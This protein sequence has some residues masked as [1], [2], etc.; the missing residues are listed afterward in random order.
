MR[1][2]SALPISDLA[3]ASKV[4]ERFVGL[5][6]FSPVEQM[7]LLEIIAGEKTDERTIARSLDFCK[8]I[9]KTP[10]VIN[11]GYGFYTTRVFSTYL[12]EGAQLV[13]E[14]HAPAAIEWAARTAG[15]VIGPLQV[16]DEVTLTLARKAMGQAEKY[17]SGRARADEGIA[18]IQAMVDTHARHGK[19]A[20]AGFYNYENGKR[21]GFWPGLAE[22]AKGTVEASDVREVGERLLLIQA[23]EAVR[24]VEE[25]I[26]QRN[27]DVEVGAIF[28]IGFAPNSGG[29]LSYIDRL[30]ARE[31]VAKLRDFAERFGA[32]YEPPKLLVEMA[33]SGK[34]FFDAV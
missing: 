30:G 6:F 3:T 15:M 8:R 13:S 20:G 31:A 11:D 9:G 24:A 7:P 34:R 33:E 19:S 25:G 14:G 29:P 1:N 21:T 26:I 28:G 10:I 5:H 12:M 27:R 18:L 23:A 4:P 32:R 17:M 2:T 16:F 22:L